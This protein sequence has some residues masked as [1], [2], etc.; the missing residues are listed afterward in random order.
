MEET[1]AD[2]R[3]QLEQEKK[4]REDAERRLHGNTL[5]SIMRQR[6][7]S[8]S[9]AI[10]VENDATLATQDDVT[11]PVDRHFPKCITPCDEFSR[12]QRKICPRENLETVR[13]ESRQTSNYRAS[14]R[15]PEPKEHNTRSRA[16]AGASVRFQAAISTPTKLRADSSDGD[17]NQY[18]QST[19]EAPRK[20]VSRGESSRNKSHEQQTCGG[21]GKAGAGQHSLRNDRATVAYCTIDCIHGIVN[22]GPL[23]EQC[24]NLQTHQRHSS[25]HSHSIDSTEFVRRLHDQL[26]ENADKGFEQ[27][28]IGGRTGFLLK[29]TLFSHGYTVII[30]ATTAENQ[31]RLQ[32]EVKNYDRLTSL[33][34]RQ[35]P[36]C[37]GAFELRI[38]LVP[39]SNN[40]TYDDLEL[41][42]NATS[43]YRQRPEFYFLQPN[44]QGSFS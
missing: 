5:F 9:E 17:E 38:E 32:E 28:H 11:D 7:H 31:H 23:D 12:L 10:Q 39:R 2:L 37:L 27:L 14:H 8:L 25:G 1:I 42:W 36:V 3:R 6:H 30:K 4:A 34:G 41:V 13:S 24:P 29:A 20:Q 18:F 26:V 19:P 22:R 16:R 44:A 21:Y 15:K 40:G 43:T 33:Q 35:I